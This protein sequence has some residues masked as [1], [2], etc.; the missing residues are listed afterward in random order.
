[1][2]YAN[3]LERMGMTF[4]IDFGLENA[5]GMAWERLEQGEFILGHA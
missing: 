3:Y 1:M 2:A 4:L 5:E